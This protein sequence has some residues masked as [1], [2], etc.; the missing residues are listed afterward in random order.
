MS[1]RAITPGDRETSGPIYCVWEIT[2][3]CDLGCRHCGSRAGQQRPEEL[4][5]GECLE[6]VDQLAK[7]GV[8]EVTLIGGEAYLR[9][10][11]GVIAAAIDEA[12]MICTITTG[13]RNLTDE[14][15]E[16]AV[17]AGVT[18]ISISLDGLGG[19]HDAQR[20]ARGSFDAAVDAARRIGDTPIRLG[21]NTQINRLSLPELDGLTA[22]LV[23]LGVEAWQV[24]LT[25]P[26]GRAADR[27]GLLLQP[28]D[29]L[30]LFP[31][32][33]WLKE[34]RLDP[35][36]IVFHPANNVGYF[37]PYEARL[38]RGGERGAYWRGCAAGK[39]VLG[40][41]AD[42][43]IKGC[44]SLPTTAYAGGNLRDIEVVEALTREPL[45][46]MQGRTTADLWGFC[47]ECYYGEICLAGC[48]WTSH[49]V[50]GR[51]GNN[52]YCIHRALEHEKQGLRERLVK[53]EA[54]PGEP[55]DVG[56]FEVVLEPDEASDSTPSLVDVLSE[57]GWSRREL[58]RILRADPT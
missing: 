11:W 50:L 21:V 22:L 24:Q 57:G 46:R 28:Y 37:G 23:E 55:F 39:Y 47:Q 27:P 26:M 6:V 56:R 32:L 54:A 2:L 15:L 35:A 42:G 48:T 52:P 58:A 30:T 17:R 3:A 18:A 14:R 43:T 36:G 25:V 29:L 9:E 34:T 8:R 31:L 16:T 38:R 4:T 20:G 45:Q 7:V 13:A 49:A 51:P 53:T 12:G 44:P 1:V 40:L 19:T 41:E 10:D 5:T 33:V